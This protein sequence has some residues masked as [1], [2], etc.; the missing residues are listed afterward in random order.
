MILAICVITASFSMFLVSENSTKSK[1]LQRVFGINPWMYHLVN[2]I[3]D[4]VFY[5]ICIFLILLTYWSVGTDLFTFTA[6]AFGTTLICFI[7]YGF[8]ILPFIY[9]CQMFFSIPSMAFAIISLGLFLF[10][11]VS[12]TTVML[13]ENL[14]TADQGLESANYVCSI[15]FL[16]IPP[17]NL[18]MAI[19]RLSFIHNLRIFGGKFLENIGRPD[20]IS[21]LPLPLLSEWDLMGKHIVCLFIS[22]I[23][24]AALLMVIEYRHV[25]FKFMRYPQLNLCFAK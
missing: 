4:F 10:G 3:Y 1:H 13:L 23:F 12:T 9:I 24:Y 18:G 25:L 17:Y 11:V 7:F 16:I 5:I 19:N 6:E 22:A 20:L 14:Q 15:V 8:C 21:K 2:F